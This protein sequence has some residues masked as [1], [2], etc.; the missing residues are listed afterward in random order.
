[1]IIVKDIAAWRER[2]FK[3]LLSVALVVGALST[4]L[5]MPF[6]VSHAMW[7]VAA[8]DTVAL[9]WIF[10]ISRFPHLRYVTRVVHFLTIVYALA[11]VLFLAIGPVSLTYLLGPPLI[12]AILLGLRPAMLAL[13]LGAVTL[14]GLGA[15]GWVSLS[16]PG[17][18]DPVKASLAAALNY[19]TIGAILTLTCSTLLKG[20]SQSL[21]DLRMF[22]VT[23]EEKQVVL[24]ELNSEL[25]LTSAAVSHLKDMVLIIKATAH[26]N[27]ARPIIFVN[28][29]F[30]RRSGY[31][32]TE[33]VGKSLAV[34]QGER[35]DAVVVAR[36]YAAII[37]DQACSAELMCYERNGEAF[38][39]E[40]DLLPFAYSGACTS[41][42]VVV[43]RD[44]GE[45]RAA[46]DS[47]HR[48]AFYDGLTGLAN[49]RLLMARIE[50]LLGHSDA[51]NQLGAL[52]YLNLDN[53]KNV[54]DALGHATGDALLTHAA[55]RLSQAVRRGDTV[56]RI[57]GD[58]FVILI[59]GLGSDPECATR[60]A[61]EF[62]NQV[63]A[64][65]AAPLNLDGQVCSIAASIGVA[66]TL[67]SD[68]AHDLLRE[69]DTAMYQAKSG[70]RKGV[71]L[72]ERAMLAETQHKLTLE[73]DL[74]QALERGELAMHLQL[75]VD[76]YGIPAGAELLM[77]WHRADGVAV[78]PDHFIPVAESSGLI[79]AL[80]HWAL[81]QTCEA[82]NALNQ[83]GH[84]M[85]LS[86]NVSPLQFRQP[87][88]VDQ[89]REV[90][91]ATGVSPRNI[92][93]EVTEG[94]LIEDITQTIARMRELVEFGIR[95]SI[96]DFGTGY[97]NLAYLIKMPL[98]ELKIDKSFMRDIPSDRNSTAIVQSILA[99]A[100]HLGL[101]VVA[102]GIESEAQAY[103]LVQQGCLY[104]QG[105]L[106]HRPMPLATLISLLQ[107][108]G[109][110]DTLPEAV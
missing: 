62:A 92:I 32:R 58:E 34:F 73:R 44:I 76:R 88:F 7:P 77:R 64:R 63:R 97:S 45:R 50:R 49:R 59:E 87:D 85:Q 60:A 19:T 90:F 18:D 109:Q 39:V 68:S 14:F 1:M 99:M 28:D 47:I 89:V 35:T 57:G 52:L 95:F 94:L 41:H 15:T 24:N 38:W 98:Y 30:L 36:L 13:A 102:E 83:A 23:L 10:A 9:I 103:Y 82:W 78:R 33:I 21:A 53:F 96:D 79:V 43:G 27:A 17:W 5:I 75:Q 40:I 22:A 67:H 46:A 12:A 2:I 66:L 100:G 54:N 51:R 56:S 84:A 26:S 107:H 74:A 108:T 20:L 11:I 61:L 69:A 55:A 65:L 16:V 70:G 80:G 101:R 72:F 48:L 86:V 81:R 110:A 106:Y 37:A 6:L 3:S 105:F 71:V 8:A 29:A 42:W 25:E 4:I 31:A 93:F 91:I 104:M